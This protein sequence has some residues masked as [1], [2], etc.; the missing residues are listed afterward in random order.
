M[1]LKTIEENLHAKSIFH[2]ND[3][4][5]NFP[6]VIGY[7]KLFKWRWVATQ[8][9]TFIVAV[10][11]GD[12]KVTVD[13]VERVLGESFDYAK[14]HYKGW[15]R[16]FQSG[17]GVI[18]ILISNQLDEQAIEY[19]EKIK[20]GKKWAGFSVPVVL[21]SSTYETHYFKKNPMWGRIYFPHFKEL[22][23]QVTG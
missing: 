23:N 10:D 15:P 4:I 6:T 14:K 3:S 16:G 8:L 2:S 20:S 22:I 13:L 1:T 21:N 9:N 12:T 7:E 5:Q 17:I 11:L 18:S 19:C